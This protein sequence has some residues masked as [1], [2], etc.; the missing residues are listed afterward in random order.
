MDVVT[1]IIALYADSEQLIS[2]TFTK[3]YL[4][5]LKATAMFTGHYM[6]VFVGGGGVPRLHLCIL[7]RVLFIIITNRK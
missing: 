7:P 4:Y 5:C 2:L 3:I 6:C 1:I